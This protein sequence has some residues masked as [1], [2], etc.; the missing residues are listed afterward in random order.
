MDAD[1]TDVNCQIYTYQ[2]LTTVSIDI[3]CIVIIRVGV[4][5]RNLHKKP[6]QSYRGSIKW[7]TNFEPF[8]YS[9]FPQA[10][11]SLF[12]RVVGILKKV[13]WWTLLHSIF[14]KKKPKLQLHFVKMINLIWR[15]LSIFYE[16]KLCKKKN[17]I[18]LKVHK[19][20]SQV[21]VGFLHEIPCFSSM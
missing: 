8:C 17:I 16:G 18:L 21:L 11:I 19:L 5:N 9:S 14:H 13:M 4:K 1:N 3:I 15:D 10:S 7:K 20:Y 6:C 12:W 2:L